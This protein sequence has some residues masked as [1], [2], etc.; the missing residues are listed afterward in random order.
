M[1]DVT[2]DSFVHPLLLKQISL[3]KLWL[4]W[5]PRVLISPEIQVFVFQALKSREIAHWCWKKS[6]FL[7]V[8]VLTKQITR[9]IFL[10]CDFHEKLKL[11]Y[12]RHSTHV[13]LALI[14]SRFAITVD[15]D[16]H[17]RYYSM[18]WFFG[19]SNAERSWKSPETLVYHLSG[20]LLLW[21]HR[22]VIRWSD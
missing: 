21:C 2:D 14:A 10:W 9:L 4:L 5:F 11:K 17:K 19:I 15:L 22:E 1:K 13:Y 6:W 20:N 8:V 16:G 12:D 3:L 7:S 18:S